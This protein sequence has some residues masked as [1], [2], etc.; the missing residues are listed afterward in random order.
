MQTAS[1][2]ISGL[3]GEKQR[4]TEQSKEFAAQTKRLVGGSSRAEQN[5][6]RYVS[7]SQ[8]LLKA[9]WVLRLV[10]VAPGDVLLATAFLSYS[11][12]FNQEFRN[13]LLSDWQQELKQRCIPFEENLNLTEL[14]IDA[15]TVSEWNLQVR[16]LF[17]PRTGDS[18]KH[19]APAQQQQQQQRFASFMD[20]AV[21]AFGI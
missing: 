6:S 16:L 10:L 15:P 18:A 2:L 8:S 12:P 13:L 5:A 21:A 1:S 17:W 7:R 3:A 4:W 14:L 19:C 11:G 9:W 20:C